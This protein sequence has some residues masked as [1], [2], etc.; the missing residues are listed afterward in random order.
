MGGGTKGIGAKEREKKRARQDKNNVVIWRGDW[1]KE[2]RVTGKVYNIVLPKDFVS[3][4]KIVTLLLCWV[5]RHDKG[6]SG[7]GMG[8]VG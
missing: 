1:G 6:R 7:R 5:R 4:F 3:S 2:R 8:G